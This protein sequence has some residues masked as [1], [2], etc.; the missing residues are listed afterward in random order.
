MKKN[1]KK[2]KS[3]VAVVMIFLSACLYTGFC[4]HGRR[5]KN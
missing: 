1:E 4:E 3:I 2:L 5:G